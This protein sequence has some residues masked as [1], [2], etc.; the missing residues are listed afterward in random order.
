MLTDTVVVMGSILANTNSSVT[1]R[2]TLDV[3]AMEIS[4]VN[5]L[6]MAMVPTADW[7]MADT[8]GL[9]GGVADEVV[10]GSMVARM[11]EAM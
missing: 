4:A 3:L 2:G 5:S 6:A 9:V 7:V 1:A 10:N 8:V 11:V